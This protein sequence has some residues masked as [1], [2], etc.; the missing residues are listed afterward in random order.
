MNQHEQPSRREGPVDTWSILAESWL[1]TSI[2]TENRTEM[3]R[4]LA[5]EGIVGS[6]LLRRKLFT[7]AG[8][9]WNILWWEWAYLGW[10]DIVFGWLLNG[11]L[12][13]SVLVALASHWSVG[14]VAF[15]LL[16]VL[17]RKAMPQVLARVPK[18]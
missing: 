6:R 14:L 13:L 18:P 3:R 9:W 16:K 11:C 17:A 15:V 12:L 8:L 10:E 5:E 1:D 4:L 2:G 7:A